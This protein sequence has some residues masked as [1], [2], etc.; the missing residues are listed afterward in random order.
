MLD[1]ILFHIN[2]SEMLDFLPE[3]SPENIDLIRCGEGWDNDTG[4][5]TSQ[6]NF[7][8]LWL[9]DFGYFN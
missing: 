9:K 6:P 3:N 8:V 7:F 1:C 5:Q 2:L 4:T